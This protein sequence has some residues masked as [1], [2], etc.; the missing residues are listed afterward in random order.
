M[1]SF[2]GMECDVVYR[3][4]FSTL[5]ALA[6]KPRVALLSIGAISESSYRGEIARRLARLATRASRAGNLPI[7]RKAKAA[8]VHSFRVPS[9]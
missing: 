9:W 7:W 8:L 1:L 3:A 6:G 2:F 5:P 4:V